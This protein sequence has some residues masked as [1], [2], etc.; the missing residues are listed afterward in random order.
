MV[1]GLI[2]RGYSI[3]LRTQA[4]ILSGLERGLGQMEIMCWICEQ[5]NCDYNTA[6]RI[7]ETV[8]AISSRKVSA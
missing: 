1:N 7:I 2:V 4:L 3:S 8:K 6:W 5:F